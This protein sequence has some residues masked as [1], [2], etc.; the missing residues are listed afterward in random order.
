VIEKQTDNRG[1]EAIYARLTSK[2][3]TD[4]SPECDAAGSSIGV[5][6][7]GLGTKPEGNEEP[8]Y[9]GELMK[10]FDSFFITYERSHAVCTGLQSDS[11]EYDKV[12]N[13][14]N[15]EMTALE[16][17]VKSVTEIK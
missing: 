6:T 13:E 17:A 5:I 7:K 16:T 9:Y 12:V 1:K 10:Q 3:L 8:R 14:Q 4:I 11:A 15:R 2:T